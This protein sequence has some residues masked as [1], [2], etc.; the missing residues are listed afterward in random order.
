MAM[1]VVSPKY[2]KVD[3]YRRLCGGKMPR[4]LG[5]PGFDGILIHP[6]STALDSYGCV[7]VGKNT[8]KGTVT[9][10][11]DTF[12]ALYAKLKAASDRGEQITIEI[13]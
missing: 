3:W 6:G 7:L 4:L 1:N 9:S 5:V 11:R 13:F 2:A 12:S 8:K 10:S